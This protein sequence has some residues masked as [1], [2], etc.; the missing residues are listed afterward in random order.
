M[1]GMTE[2]RS[3]PRVAFGVLVESGLVPAGTALTDA[4]RRWTA[5]VRADGSIACGA[6]A[7]SIHKVGA[8]LQPAPSCNGWNFWH[9]EQSGSLTLLDAL[10]QQHLA[11]L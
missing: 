3:A 9:V 10:R 8:A 7:G 6:H 5:S 2:S 1:T 4:K 11:A